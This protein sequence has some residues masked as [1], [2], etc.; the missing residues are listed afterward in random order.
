MHV[1]ISYRRNVRGR[2]SALVTNLADALEMP[3]VE[4]VLDRKHVVDQDTFASELV[5]RGLNRCEVLI[6]LIDKNWLA[7]HNV[8]RLRA[9]AAIEH[10]TDWVEFE[11]RYALHYG[12]ALALVGE[13]SHLR[14]VDALVLPWPLSKLAGCE[15]FATDDTTIDKVAAR[16]LIGG[17]RTMCDASPRRGAELCA[18][19][20]HN[21]PAI[22]NSQDALEYAVG[23]GWKMTALIFIGR[24]LRQMLTG[25]AIIAALMAVVLAFKGEF[26]NALIGV[27][28]AAALVFFVWLIHRVSAS[29]LQILVDRQVRRR[30]I[31][32]Y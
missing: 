14:Q 8:A 4:V 9:S 32:G 29:S 3:D 19:A 23:T 28:M 25:L 26:A 1:F 24:I 16:D 18:D 17:L 15:R 7:S 31:D 20:K 5:D 27:V 13:L 21:N 11:L 2:P 10:S 22:L 30:R 12:L 6:A